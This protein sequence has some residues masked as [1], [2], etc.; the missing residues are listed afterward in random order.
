M[1]CDECQSWI[2]EELSGEPMEAEP[3]AAARA[4]RSTC[5]ECE[6]F[7]T[8]SREALAL[9]ALPDVSAGDRKAL[10][11]LAPA[12]LARWDEVDRRRR[13][14]RWVAPLTAAAVAALVLLGWLLAEAPSAAGPD[15]LSMPA[16]RLAEKELETWELARSLEEVASLPLQ[17]TA[18]EAEGDLLDLEVPWPIEPSADDVAIS[19]PGDNP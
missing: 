8:S 6:A 9:A 14:T 17:A 2:L 19:P 7:A 16:P 13:R 18:A 15:D 5:P 10:S 3:A 12:A 11:S 4:H 1:T